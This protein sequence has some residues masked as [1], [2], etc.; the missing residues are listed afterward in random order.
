MNG[1]GLSHG[2]EVSNN[3]LAILG[4]GEELSVD[5]SQGADETLVES[6]QGLLAGAAIIATPNVDLSVGATGVTHATIVPSCTSE[7][8][9][10]VGSEKTLLLVSRSVTSVPEVH[11]LDTSSGESL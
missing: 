5:D 4:T 3:N 10:F 2:G 1:V 11:V 7:R 8:G 9:L 6:I